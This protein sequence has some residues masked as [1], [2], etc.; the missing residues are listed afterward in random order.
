[1]FH[2]LSM[3]VQFHTQKNVLIGGLHALYRRIKYAISQ[4]PSKCKQSLALHL[5][6]KQNFKTP[7]VLLAVNMFFMGRAEMGCKL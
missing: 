1:M 4:A 5:Q 3:Y 6:D 7:T 2:G